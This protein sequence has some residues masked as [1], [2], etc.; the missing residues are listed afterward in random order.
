MAQ[1]SPIPLAMLTERQ[2]ARASMRIGPNMRMGA[3]VHVTTGGILAIGLLVSGI[4][5]STAVLVGASA[6]G[7]A[8]KG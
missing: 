6:R 8:R 5:L 7:R 1:K 4:L 3:N 2:G